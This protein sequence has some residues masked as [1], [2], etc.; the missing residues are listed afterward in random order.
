VSYL[1]DTTALLAHYRDEEGSDRV[2]EL[3]DAEETLY[4]CSVSLTEFARR[5]KS[6]GE[7]LHI[8]KQ[9][10][11]NYKLLLDEVIPVDEALAND[12]FTLMCDL[13]QRLPLVDAFI[14]TAA[15]RKGACLVHRDAHFHILPKQTLSTLDISK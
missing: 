9:T 15:Q 2:Q 11:Y 6:L 3:F 7:P 5:M 10:L 13:P 1:L 8:I 14:A 12:T 4:L